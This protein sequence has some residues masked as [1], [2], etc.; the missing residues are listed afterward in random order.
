M[1]EKDKT[2]Q[3][4]KKKRDNLKTEENVKQILINILSVI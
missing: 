2:I 3:R 1:S 4:R